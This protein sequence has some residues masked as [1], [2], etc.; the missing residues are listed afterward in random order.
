MIFLDDTCHG[1]KEQALVRGEIANALKGSNN[2]LLCEGFGPETMYFSEEVFNQFFA[3]N[4]DYDLKTSFTAG[5]DDTIVHKASLE[6][7]RN[8]TEDAVQLKD[9]CEDSIQRLKAGLQSVQITP[10]TLKQLKSPEDFLKAAGFDTDT[11]SRLVGSVSKVQEATGKDA[12]IR[13]KSAWNA[14]QQFRGM[15]PDAQNHGFWRTRPQ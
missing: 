15:F 1:D 12:L 9:F 10:E 7:V 3:P 11:F 5:W 6:K 8:G 14:I 4:L 13:T 2:I